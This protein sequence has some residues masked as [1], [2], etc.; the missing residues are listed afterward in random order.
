MTSGHLELLL[1][2]HFRARNVKIWGPWP[3]PRVVS[4]AE[5]WLKMPFFVFHPIPH[6]LL[7]IFHYIIF[8]KGAIHHKI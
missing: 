5:I 7:F 8:K 6:I 4:I 1:F 2:Q 3:D